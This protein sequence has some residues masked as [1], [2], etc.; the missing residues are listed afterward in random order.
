MIKRI[1]KGIS[2][3]LLKTLLV[4]FFL[5]L[6]RWM[7]LSLISDKAVC[8]FCLYP[9][10]IHD[11]YLSTG[12]SKRIAVS[13]INVTK[14]VYG[15]PLSVEEREIVR[16]EDGVFVLLHYEGFAVKFYTEDHQTYEYDGFELY[17]PK[18]KIRHDIHVGS[19][20]EQIKKAYRRACPNISEEY[21]PWKLGDSY[22]DSIP[23]SWNDALLFEYDENDIVTSIW[24]NP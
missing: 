6:G 18:I 16:N 5:A 8:P 15:E 23:N 24:Y 12:I 7:L 2:K 10:V 21:G 4:I 19:T 1:L 14:K 9:H 13:D 3:F 17:S 11:Y 20:R 22:F